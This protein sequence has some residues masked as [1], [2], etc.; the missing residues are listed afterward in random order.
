M[1]LLL[2]LALMQIAFAFNA[3]SAVVNNH[4]SIASLLQT[5]DRPMLAGK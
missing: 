2:A 4:S 1:A 5:Q 3:G